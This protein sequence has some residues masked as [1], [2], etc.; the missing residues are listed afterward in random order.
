MTRGG[1]AAQQITANNGQH[2]TTDNGQQTTTENEQ[3]EQQELFN[4]NKNK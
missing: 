4:N 3:R 2:W 1:V